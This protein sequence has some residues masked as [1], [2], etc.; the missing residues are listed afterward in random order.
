[1]ASSDE[2]LRC[3]TFQSQSFCTSFQESIDGIGTTDALECA[4]SEARALILDMQISD[5]ECGSKSS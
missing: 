5:P 1:M 4:Q 2:V 3:A